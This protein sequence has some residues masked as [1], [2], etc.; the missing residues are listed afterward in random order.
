MGYIY[1]ITSEF[2]RGQIIRTTVYLL[3]YVNFQV[4]IHCFTH[5]WL[6]KDL[7]ILA[8]KIDNK[9]ISVPAVH[10]SGNVSV[11]KVW[12]RSLWT[13]VYIKFDCLWVYWLEN[14]FLLVWLVLNWQCWHSFCVQLTISHLCENLLVFMK[15]WML[16]T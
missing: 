15:W 1:F 6:V 7:K 2:G 10:I 3:L 8:G 12:S 13:K 9:S 16:E 5:L 11:V 14:I 4:V